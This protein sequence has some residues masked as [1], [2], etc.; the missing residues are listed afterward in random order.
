MNGP[1]RMARLPVPIDEPALC[2]W[3][4]QAMPGD[5]V[6]YHRGFLARDRT[7]VGKPMTRSERDGLVRTADRAR[8]LAAQGLVHLVQRRHG[9]EDYGYLAV[10]RPRPGRDVRLAAAVP[11]REA[12]R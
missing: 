5:V 12:R 6:E 4:G 9:P 7:D 3:V 8:L 1:F 11:A 2:A 10:A